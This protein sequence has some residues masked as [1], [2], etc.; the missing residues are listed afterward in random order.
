[1]SKK[2]IVH[3]NKFDNINDKKLVV[4]NIKIISLNKNIIDNE[5]LLLYY[6]FD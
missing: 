3:K 2:L 1:M 4:I 6:H 5:Y